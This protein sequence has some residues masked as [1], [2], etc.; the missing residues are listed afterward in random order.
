M[1]E[2]IA[3]ANLAELE[4]AIVLLTRESEANLPGKEE[5]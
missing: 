1:T 3:A 5:L 4:T 2:T